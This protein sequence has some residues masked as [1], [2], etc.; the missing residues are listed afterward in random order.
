MA[1][2]GERDL[3]EYGGKTVGKECKK[4][5]QKTW[6]RAKNQLWTPP[7]FGVWSAGEDLPTSVLSVFS[8]SCSSPFN[9]FCGFYKKALCV[10]FFFL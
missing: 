5:G 9:W 3:E 1:N 4:L 8:S 6:K 10:L 7:V 2:P